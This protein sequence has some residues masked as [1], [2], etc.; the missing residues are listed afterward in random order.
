[1]MDCYDNFG[2]DYVK[3]Y[4]KLLEVE[5]VSLKPR[6]LYS[7][8]KPTDTEYKIRGLHLDTGDK[9]L[10]GLWYFKHPDEPDD[11]GGDLFLLNPETKKHKKIK[12][13]SNCFVIFPNLMTAWH[14][15]TPRKPCKFPR[16]YVNL[17]LE[18]TDTTLHNYRR[19]G[20]SV[21][22]EFRGKLIN[23]YK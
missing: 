11:T 7:E 22:D 18:S 23:Y 21:D 1:M 15:V 17:L 10:I 12:Y 13:K 6:I 16:R 5:G 19:A 9:F 20:L 2:L 4:P 8:N 3:Q 14:S